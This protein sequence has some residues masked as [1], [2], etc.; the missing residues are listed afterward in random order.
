MTKWPVYKQKQ[1]NT[2]T[3]RTPSRNRHSEKNDLLCVFQTFLFYIIFIENF[4]M[5]SFKNVE[6]PPWYGH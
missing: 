2:K 3:R 4:V 1:N 6:L 5:I